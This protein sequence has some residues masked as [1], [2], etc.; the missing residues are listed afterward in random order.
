MPETCRIDAQGANEV[1]R[2]GRYS[3]GVDRATSERV[4][5]FVGMCDEEVMRVFGFCS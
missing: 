5:S 4:D 1:M 2:L 3:Q